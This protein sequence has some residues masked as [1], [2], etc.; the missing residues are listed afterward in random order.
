MPIQLVEEYIQA[1]KSKK[2]KYYITVKLDV[3]FFEYC[4]ISV[5]IAMFMC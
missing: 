1:T 5:N 3:L 4:N 2:C